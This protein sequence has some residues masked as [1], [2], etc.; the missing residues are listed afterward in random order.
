MRT[1]NPN[2]LPFTTVDLN[3]FCDAG[4]SLSGQ[5]AA[6]EF[7]AL[8]DDVGGSLQVVDWSVQ[9]SSKPVA[10][11]QFDKSTES[12]YRF[13][14]VKASTQVKATC[15]RCL[16]EMALKLVVDT[17]L[18][19]FQT[20]EAADQAAMSADADTLSDPIV[21][22]RTF[23]LLDQIQEELLLAMPENPMHDDGDVLCILPI[24]VNNKQT[25][26]L[27]FA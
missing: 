15:G 16:N 27:L 9:G 22:S 2:T 12:H 21:A 3:A 19:A 11:A 4:K 1:A 26:A 5:S 18:Q 10:G 23:D 17:Q 8:D 6:D 7:G 20:D 24:V 13:L 14:H 25:S